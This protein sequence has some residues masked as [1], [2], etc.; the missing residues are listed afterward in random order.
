MLHPQLPASLLYQTPWE[1]S[2][3]SLQ[4]GLATTSHPSLFFLQQ[5]RPEAPKKAVAAS[6]HPAL[7]FPS[8][9]LG[10]LPASMSIF[11]KVPLA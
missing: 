5:L 7:A 4:K 8:Q 11:K 6:F 2:S 3:C 10:C 1:G 9:P